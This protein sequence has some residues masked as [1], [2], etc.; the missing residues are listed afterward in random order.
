MYINVFHYFQTAGSLK[1]LLFCM[2][3]NTQPI[4]NWSNIQTCFSGMTELFHRA[5]PLTSFWSGHLLFCY[6]CW[7][8]SHSERS[9]SARLLIVT[10]DYRPVQQTNDL[11]AFIVLRTFPNRTVY[12][13]HTPVPPL[14]SCRIYSLFAFELENPAMAGFHV[15]SHTVRNRS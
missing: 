7:S 4:F 5:Q 10:A 2:F 3:L 14:P 9:L 12:I 8:H 15:H 13:L 6:S 11:W 1:Q